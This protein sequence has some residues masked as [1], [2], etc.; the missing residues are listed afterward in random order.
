MI[1]HPRGRSN[2]RATSRDQFD[3][4]RLPLCVPERLRELPWVGWKYHAKPD[5]VKAAKLPINPRTGN[6]SVSDPRSW[7]DFGSALAAAASYDL[8]GVGVV[9]T[10]QVGLTGVDLDDCRDPT[11][12]ELDLWA[13]R[14]LDRLPGTYAECSPS[15]RGVRS[16]IEG[17]LPAGCRN[18]V[19]D[20]EAY[21]AGRFLTITG[22]VL[23]DRPLVVTDAAGGL[24]WLVAEFLTQ[25]KRDAKP[26]ATPG[27]TGCDAQLLQ[28]AM[29]QPVTG[30]RLAALLAGELLDHR[31]QSEADYELCRILGFWCG[32][33]PVRVMAILRLLP[34]IVRSGMSAA[35]TQLGSA[36]RFSRPLP[37]WEE[38][39]PQEDP[40]HQRHKTVKIRVSHAP[41][42]LRPGVRI[43]SSPI[44][45]DSGCATVGQWA[46]RYDRR[47][48]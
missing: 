8:D 45:E 38:S 1:L 27:F 7:G 43:G 46:F 25:R 15:R 16:F 6:A 20:I 3:P 44:F 36:G 32:G 30:P 9:L 14:I 18:R 11:T 26:L 37:T 19:G 17:V 24:N 35:A 23:P 40:L 42:P 4:G 5:R 28:R 29:R 13:R 39:T 31:S 12:G 47:R 48:K 21:S 22:S 41:T 2:P 33:D 34:P 10:P